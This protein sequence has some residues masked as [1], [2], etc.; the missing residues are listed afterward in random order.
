[1]RVR[2]RAALAAVVLSLIPILGVFSIG[3]TPAAAAATG[4]SYIPLSPTRVADTRTG[5]QTIDGLAAGTGVVAAGEARRLSIGGRGGVAPDA[6]AVALNVTA[7]EATTGTYLTAYPAGSPRPNASNL[8]VPP[9]PAIANLV[10]AKL[11]TGGQIDV[12][13]DKGTVHVVADVVGYFPAGT[14]LTAFAPA[15]Y[16]DTRPAPLGDTFDGTA[17][18]GGAVGP[19]GTLNLTVTGRGADAIPA[20]AGSVI[21]NVTA[22]QA[23]AG[24]FVTVH[25]TGTSRPNASN[26][27]VKP[28]I[29]VPNLVIAKIGT[30]GRV[31]LYNDKGSTHLIADVVGWLPTDATAFTG[32][33]PARLL[34]TR[35]APTGATIDGVNRG[36]GAVAGGT[37]TAVTVAGRGGVPATGAGAVVLNVT[38]TLA[39]AQTY[40]TAFPSGETRPLA[41]NLNLM[42]G[43]DV[44]NLVIAKIGAD[45]KVLLYNDRGA[46]HLIADVVGWFPA[47]DS[48]VKTWGCPE[49]DTGTCLLT[50]VRA[51]PTNLD[52]FSPTNGPTAVA[53]GAN[54]SL[55]LLTDGT[56]VAW[57]D[58]ASGQLGTGTTMATANPTAVTGLGAGSGVAQVAAGRGISLARRTNGTVL[59]WGLAARTP[60]AVTFPGTASPAAAV[61]AGENRAGAVLADGSLWAWQDDQTTATLVLNL[62][63]RSVAS[64][65]GHV[66]VLM[67]DGGVW[68]FGENTRGQLGDGTTTSRLDVNASGFAAVTGL[69]AGS[70]VIAVAAGGASSYALKVD[71]SVLA[72]GDGTRGQLG[73]GAIVATPVVVPTAVSG[74]AAGSGVTALTAGEV[75]AAALKADGSVLAWGD[76]TR[77]QTGSGVAATPVVVPTAVPGLAAGSGVTAI[78]A[79]GHHTVVLR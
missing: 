48:P 77:A 38:A 54:H 51:V 15:R 6:V 53:T 57:G 3:A 75:H 17:R 45:G 29:D 63:V 30:T 27:N 46:T 28:G 32:L 55:A 71:G 52:G 20:T 2:K 8:N 76:A 66:L 79:R 19:G 49:W 13:N 47:A 22:T 24:T 70:G 16:L 43:S 64:G 50:P 18:R 62:G 35:P 61:F 1:M 36:A 10:V 58:N 42:P 69:G 40:V 59:T 23:T 14:A 21:L 74:L 37:S 4:S 72:W 34:D 44:P 9:G 65:T 25:P 68:S 60:V 11:G 39:S 41:S 56:V 26:L 12:Y 67:G 33:T 78:V 73:G 7:T 5:A 31:T